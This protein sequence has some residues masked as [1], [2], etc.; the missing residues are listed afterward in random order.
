[1][2][3]PDDSFTPPF[4][5]NPDCK[6]HRNSTGWRFKKNG[7]HHR[8]FDQRDIQRYRCHHC[9][10]SF[11]TQTFS[12][13]YWLKRPDLLEPVLHGLL[14]CSGYRQIARATGVS[15]ATIELQA[16]RL[17]RHM[18]LFH[19]SQRPRHAPREPL[20]VDGFETFEFSQYWVTHLNTVVGAE[21]HFAYATTVAE[22]RR[23]GR[24]TKRQKQRRG[25]LELRYG[26]PD[27]KSIEKSMAEALALVVPLGADEVTVRSDDHRA[28]PRAL[29]RLD[30][31]RFVH[32]V[33]SSK[34]RRT[35]QNPLFPA[36]L[37][38]LLM[39]HGGANQKRETIAYSKRNQSML[40]RDA[41]HRVWRNFAKHV[42]ER[43]REGSPAMRLDL[44][45]RLLTW[46]EILAQRLFVARVGL[47]DPLSGYYWG[48]VPTRQLPQAR[49]HQ[50]RYAS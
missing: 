13:T 16:A 32:E 4:C 28:Y 27:P 1:M 19:E 2:V 10:R 11:S 49:N 40:W 47:P 3:E 26:R 23:K 45:P 14:S 7:T 35:P 38:H 30:P 24:M 22:L 15:P 8:R 17:G 12:T 44:T 29:R 34:A 6:F 46:P 33:T 42:S 41:V 21:S 31:R 48:R 9:N 50:L 5:P 36:N 20:V 25:E 39:R 18:L 37:L 43:R